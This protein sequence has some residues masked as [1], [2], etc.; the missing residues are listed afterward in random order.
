MPEMG[1]ISLALY[2]GSAWMIHSTTT[3]AMTI[4]D[5]VM[6]RNVSTHSPR[7]TFFVRPTAI[8]V[9][10]MH[11]PRS[12]RHTSHQVWYWNRYTSR[13]PMASSCR[14]ARTVEMAMR[15]VWPSRSRHDTTP[16][17]SISKL[18]ATSST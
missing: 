3:R 2:H 1:I 16:A 17:T 7:T 15:R 18:A 12:T 13:R 10:A 14:N 9:A 11:M 8:C 5:T 6:D 4:D